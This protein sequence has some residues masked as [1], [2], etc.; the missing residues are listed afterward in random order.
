MKFIFPQNYK[1]KNKLL[2]F[3]DYSTA[4]MNVVWCIFIWFILHLFTSKISIILFLFILLCLPVF[5]FSITG[6]F[7]ENI[8]FVISYIFK[9]FSR[10]KL[11][12]FSKKEDFSFKIPSKTTNI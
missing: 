8:L 12:L 10:P 5:L 1:F 4:I 11:Y 3:I 9:F 7:G 2:G 6:V